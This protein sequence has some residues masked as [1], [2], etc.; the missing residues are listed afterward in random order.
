MK[1]TNHKREI[2]TLVCKEVL[3]SNLSFNITCDDLFY[4]NFLN[5]LNLKCSNCKMFYK[6]FKK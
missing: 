2:K 1:A 6:G 4:Y 3:I 5:K